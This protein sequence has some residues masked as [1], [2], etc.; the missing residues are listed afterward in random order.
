MAI[1]IRCPEC[2]ATLRVSDDLAGRTVSCPKC[3]HAFLATPDVPEAKPG[4]EV[5]AGPPAARR[6]PRRRPAI[7]QPLLPPADRSRE[8]PGIR[9][10]PEPVWKREL[11]G[12]LVYIGIM[13]VGT[14]VTGLVGCVAWSWV[15]RDMRNT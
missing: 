4:G 15:A 1:V 12:G 6:A 2:S 5:Q 3:K 13:V 7:R 14:V 9:K 11:Y 10:P 8:V